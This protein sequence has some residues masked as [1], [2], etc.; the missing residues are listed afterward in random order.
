MS[1]RDP[2][3]RAKL[4]AL[5]LEK[6]AQ[7]VQVIEYFNRRAGVTP[8]VPPESMAMGFMSLCEGVKLY[9]MS[10]PNDMTPQ[11]AETTLALFVDAI[12]SQARAQATAG[13]TA[14]GS[15]PALPQNAASKKSR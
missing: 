14:T 5:M 3:F 11:L 7:I 13:V 12:M 8:P 9:C 10:S 6:R 15:A 1:A 4:N 2:R